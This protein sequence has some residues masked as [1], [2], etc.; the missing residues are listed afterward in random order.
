[1]SNNNAQTIKLEFTVDEVNIILDALGNLP[2]K[3]VYGI[4]G[5]LQGQARAQLNS[6]SQETNS[7]SYEQGE[8]IE[9][10]LNLEPQS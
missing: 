8:K 3:S 10:L 6:Q 9:S 1:M 7:D 4:I 5:Q 2:F